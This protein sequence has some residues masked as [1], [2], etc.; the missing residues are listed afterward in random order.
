FWQPQGVWI[1]PKVLDSLDNIDF[2]SGLAEAVKYGVIMD[3]SFFK[4]LESNRSAI[5][6]LDKNV[7][8]QLISRCCRLKAQVVKEDEK[9]VSGRRAILNYGHTFG[10]AIENVFGYGRYLHGEAISIGMHCAAR[11][12]KK[13]R[14]IDAELVE[15]Q[16][17]LLQFFGLPLWVEKGRET[18]LVNAMHRDKKVEKGT[19]KLILPSRL[20]HVE[21][22]DA[23]SDEE[24]FDTFLAKD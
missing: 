9:E 8:T 11:L 1:D 6:D 12:A 4:W 19:L 23:P 17:N 24:L 3:A 13:Q 15:R 10:H 22:V 21:L 18:E 16:G 7:L 2:R 20:G 5:L 14:R